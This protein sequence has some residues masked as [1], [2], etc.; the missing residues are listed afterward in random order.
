M[1]EEHT[2]HGIGKVNTY[3]IRSHGVRKEP[4]PIMHFAKN[5]PFGIPDPVKRLLLTVKEHLL[6]VALYKTWFLLLKRMNCNSRLMNFNIIA[7]KKNIK[8]KAT[9]TYENYS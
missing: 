5:V 2:V 6:I 7:G 4:N 9:R 1:L 8:K 3:C